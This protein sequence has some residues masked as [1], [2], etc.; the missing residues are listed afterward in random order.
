MPNWKNWQPWST[1]EL[2][3][4]EEREERAR[5]VR[6]L[7]EMA[8]PLIGEDGVRY[9]IKLFMVDHPRVSRTTGGTGAQSRRVDFFRFDIETWSM[10]AITPVIHSLLLGRKS[11]ETTAMKGMVIPLVGPG[12]DV[13][14][15]LGS[16][17]S[18]IAEFNV[19]CVWVKPRY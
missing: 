17:I 12:V 5:G 7:G 14:T 10:I 16:E 4:L 1:R 6:A 13:E 3:C 8:E 9:T 19:Q 2:W 18:S 15:I 11:T